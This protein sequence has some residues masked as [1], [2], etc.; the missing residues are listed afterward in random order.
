MLHGRLLSYL[1]EVA[2]AGS[3]RKA[4]ERLNVSPTAV[5]RQILQLEEMLDVQLFQRLPRGMKLTA[6]GEAC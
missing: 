2:R 6:A 1:D 4:A 5:N 3:I